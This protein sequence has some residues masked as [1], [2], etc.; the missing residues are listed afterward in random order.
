M[1]SATLGRLGA[2]LF[3]LALDLLFGLLLRPR[4]T[5]MLTMVRE[6]STGLEGESAVLRFRSAER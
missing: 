1:T 3:F 4:D 2:A 6:A 5:G